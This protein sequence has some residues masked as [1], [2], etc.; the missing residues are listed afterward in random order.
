M[1]HCRM[2]AAIA[3]GGLLLLG[4]AARGETRTPLMAALDG[5]GLGDAL[6]A[7]G[8]RV[9]GHLE[10]SWTYQASA[11]PGNAIGGRAYDFEHEDPTFNQWMLAIERA[12][13]VGPERWDLGGRMEWMWGADARKIHSTGLFDHY[14]MDPEN[15]FDL[16]QAY[17]DLAVPVGNGLRLRAGKFV[18]LYGYE[19]IDPTGNPLY[20]HSYLFGAIPFT[21]TGIMGTY[22]F[23]DHWTLDAGVTRGW[24]DAL[25]DDN[26]AMDFLGRLTWTLDERTTLSLVA[27]TGP[28]RG[29]DNGV[30]RT[31]LNVLMNR[32][33]DDRWSV[34]AEGL[35]VMDGGM[36]S[37]WYG[38]AGYVSYTVCDQLSVN[39]RGEWFRD[40]DGAVYGAATSLYEATLGLTVT[41]LPGNRWLQYLVLRPEVRFDY[42]QQAFFDG[43][44]QHDQW[45]FAID[46][47]YSY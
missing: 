37:Q 12:V 16:T 47:V 26:G 28:Q 24:D 21:Q 6:D 4:G 17:L 30:Y 15:Q 1:S 10:G 11:P 5:L 43:G 13:T 31:A 34:G 45:T 29:G 46:A 36:D 20:S 44:T 19:V 8:V 39:G 42:A 41:P 14:A 9:F 23:N 18:T 22:A 7:A 27:G 35:W 32:K 38:T 25:E 2:L 40:E 3:A 33:L